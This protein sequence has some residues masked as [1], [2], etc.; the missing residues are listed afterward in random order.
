MP[1]G[2][3]GTKRI[4]ESIERNDTMFGTRIADSTDNRVDVPGTFSYNTDRH[5]LFV[6]GTFIDDDA[7]TTSF[8]DVPGKYLLQPSSGETVE[9]RAREKLRYV[10][11]YEVLWGAAA[12]YDSDPAEGQRLFVELTD[13]ARENGYRYAFEPGN[14]RVEQLSGGAVV[15]SYLESEWGD[16]PESL[17]TDHSPFEAEGIDRTTPLNPRC[18]TAWYGVLGAKYNLAYTDGKDLPRHPTLGYTANSEDVATQEINLNIKVVAEADAT[19]SGFTASVCSLGGLIRGNASQFD[20]SKA[21]PFWDLGG[22]ISQHFTDNEPVLAA[23]IDPNR[24][25]VPVTI[26]QPEVNPDGTDIIE[27]L[28][29]AVRAEDTD[30]N[31][32]DPD[33]DGTDEGTAPRAQ[34]TSQ[35]DALQWTRSVTT[36]PTT[37]DIRRDGT[38]GLVPDVRYI[39]DG[40]GVGG[41]NNKPGRTGTAGAEI[42]KRL[43]PGEVALYIPATDPAGNITDGS[44]QY[45]TPRSSQ[46][47]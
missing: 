33:D 32:Q 20:R 4:T 3:L 35:N 14:T 16:Y 22:A 38:E 2:S 40:V 41:G 5:A 12:W 39:A 6:D 34:A 47:W 45:I 21:A 26:S 19:A 10:P 37:S 27:V 31:F 8:T 30:A 43:F 17:P 13:D 29:G 23:R 11:N 9:F 28:V 42:R 7:N 1:G 36:F 44:I 18:F 15:G 46:N 24:E 25:N